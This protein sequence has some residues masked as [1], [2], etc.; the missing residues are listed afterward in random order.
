MTLLASCELVDDSR[1]GAAIGVKEPVHVQNFSG[2]AT[3]EGVE[4]DPTPFLS[5]FSALQ[6][7]RP[8]RGSPVSLDSLTVGIGVKY[9]LSRRGEL[10]EHSEVVFEPKME[11][12]AC[13]TDL[14]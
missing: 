14:Q 8:P 3:V 7:P 5:S 6:F 11:R 2:G 1:T 10:D 12:L 9:L 13:S 4:V